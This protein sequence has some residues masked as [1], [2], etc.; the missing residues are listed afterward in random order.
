MKKHAKKLVTA[1][2]ILLTGMYVFNKYI[3]DHLLSVASPANDRVF[4]WKDLKINYTEKGNNAYPPLLLIHNLYPSSSK[5]EWSSI[6]NTLAENYHIYEIDLPGCG[7]SD[8]PAETYVN[9]MFVQLISNFITKVIGVK[10]SICALAFS[11]SFTIMTARL[12]PDLVDKIIL[13]N[14]PSIEILAKAITKKSEFTKRLIELPVIGTFLYN[15]KMCRP[16]I[17]DDYKYI[18]FYN[19]KNVSSEAIDHSYYFAHFKNSSGKYLYSSIIGNYTN[20]NILHALP[21]IRNEIHIIGN[22]SCKPV[23]QDYKKYNKTIQAQYVSNCRMY[24]QMEIPET[25]VNKIYAIMERA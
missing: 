7:K 4:I 17:A 2:T 12:N 20:I 19:D 22:G 3:D 15:C 21:K 16:A 10:T 18:Y 23:I 14:P 11:S 24:P 8:K 13:I 5:E 6:D 1:S 25:I 9:Y